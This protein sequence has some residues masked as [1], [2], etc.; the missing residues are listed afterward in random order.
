MTA[1]DLGRIAVHS[2]GAPAKPLR[3]SPRW[4]ST[5]QAF[6]AKWPQCVVC[7]HDA[8][9]AVHALSV[10][11]VVP[12]EFVRRAGRPELELDARNLMTLCEAGE[13]HHLVMGHLGDWLSYDPEVRLDAARGECR[14]KGSAEIEA[15][16]W[17]R[18]RRAGRPKHWGEMTAGEV[19]ELR[20][21][22]ERGFP[23]GGGGCGEGVPAVA[24]GAPLSHR[25]DR[26]GLS[27]SR[28]RRHGPRPRRR[29]RS[30]TR[31]SRG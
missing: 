22:L 11:H 9:P 16:G 5:R 21:R 25:S 15:M 29:R 2:Q 1:G 17:W 26:S 14:G 31:T 8:A 7:A 30:A 13:N 4:E 12:V 27:K 28:A 3:R 20:E 19:A 18:E 6:L 23:R 24:R 10:H